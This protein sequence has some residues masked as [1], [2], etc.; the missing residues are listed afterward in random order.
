MGIQSGSIVERKSWYHV[1]HSVSFFQHGRSAH[2]IQGLG[3]VWFAGAE[4]VMNFHEEAFVSGLVVA[5]RLGA[6]FPFKEYAGAL[7]NFVKTR[8]WM[9]YG[10]NP[11]A[12]PTT[13]RQD[14]K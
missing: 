5:H 14:Q 7:S 4:F 10:L 6:G 13:K 9:F 12:P 1:R 8:S 11:F 3:G 2:V